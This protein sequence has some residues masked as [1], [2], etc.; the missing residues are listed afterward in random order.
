MALA[1][2]ISAPACGTLSPALKFF[3]NF[4][5]FFEGG[6]FGATPNSVQNDSFLAVV[7]EPYVASGI[8]K[9]IG[10]GSGLPPSDA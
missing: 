1:C 8:K 4:P 2:S 3:F 7:W 5:S 9:K 6:L 10:A